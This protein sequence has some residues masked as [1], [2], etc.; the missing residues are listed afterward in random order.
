MRP[1]TVLP[2][3]DAVVGRAWLRV[4]QKGSNRRIKSDLIDMA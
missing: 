1:S 4:A 3:Q 2:E